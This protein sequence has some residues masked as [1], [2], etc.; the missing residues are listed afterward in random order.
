MGMLKPPFYLHMR[1]AYSSK[2]EVDEGLDSTRCVLA[3]F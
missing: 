3:D 2:G 1:I